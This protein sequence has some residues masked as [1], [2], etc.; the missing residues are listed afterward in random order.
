VN[1]SHCCKIR[2]ENE[3]EGSENTGIL[4]AIKR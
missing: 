3:N 4:I 2:G 1:I